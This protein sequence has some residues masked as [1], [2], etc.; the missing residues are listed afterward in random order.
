MAIAVILRH[1]CLQAHGDEFVPCDP[2]RWQPTVIFQMSGAASVSG[3]DR[4]RAWDGADVG[5]GD[6]EG[7]GT[8]AGPPG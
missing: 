6:R 1:Q 3:I 2:S 5:G 8:V 7:N 4:V